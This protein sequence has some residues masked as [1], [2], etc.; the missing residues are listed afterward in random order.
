MW[1]AYVAMSLLPCR[2]WV[3]CHVAPFRWQVTPIMIFCSLASFGF[4]IRWDHIHYFSCLK[5]DLKHHVVPDL[6][7]ILWGPLHDNFPYFGSYDF[8]S[9]SRLGFRW[10]KK[11]PYLF[12]CELS[13]QHLILW[14]PFMIAFPISSGLGFWV[15]T[16]QEAF[17]YRFN[18]S[19]AIQWHIDLSHR[20]TGDH[21]LIFWGPPLILPSNL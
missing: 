20:I 4:R 13:D 16:R 21:D 8:M 12:W 1:R 14:G 9:S 19:L 2:W 17:F 11:H 15:L 18:A 10:E 6:P 3:C 7:S 5:V